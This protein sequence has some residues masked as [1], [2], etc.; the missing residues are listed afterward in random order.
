VRRGRFLLAALTLAACRRAAPP[1]ETSHVTETRADSLVL[2][3]SDSVSVWFTDQRQDRDS[4]GAPCVERVLQVRRGPLRI[5]VPLLY[6][7]AAPVR[8]N[9]S[10]I[11]A[12]LWLHCRAIDHYRVDLHS[13]H[14]LRV[15]R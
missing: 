13:A 9:D 8:V 5:P 12:D 3:V 15:T 2:Q 6:T 14:P 1:A 4:A 10:T 11:E 7:G